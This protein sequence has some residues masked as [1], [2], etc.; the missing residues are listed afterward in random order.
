M[1]LRVDPT[2]ETERPDQAYTQEALAKFQFPE[3][4]NTVKGDDTACTKR[5]FGI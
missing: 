4:T 2:R 3:Q 5:Q 1:P